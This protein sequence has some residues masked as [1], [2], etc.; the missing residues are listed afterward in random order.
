MT[1]LPPSPTV[2]KAPPAQPLIGL[3]LCALAGVL[4]IVFASLDEA[5]VFFMFFA[6][7]CLLGA[8]VFAIRLVTTKT[9]P[10]CRSSVPK[11]ASV[12]GK[13]RAALE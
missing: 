10:E 12:C 13:C 9:C 5:L 2:R 3:I 8:A 11:A 4:F 1:D 7:L 6:L